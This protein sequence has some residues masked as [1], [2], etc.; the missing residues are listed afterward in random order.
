MRKKSGEVIE[1]EKPKNKRCP[2]CGSRRLRKLFSEQ[3]GRFVGF[4]CRS[5]SCFHLWCPNP[6]EKPGLRESIKERAR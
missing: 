4:Q 3:T 1:T 2:K 5:K 6:G